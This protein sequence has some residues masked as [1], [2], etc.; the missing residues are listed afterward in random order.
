MK[1]ITI[2]GARA[3]NLKNI[4]I[5]IPKNKLVVATGVSGSG[6]S[7]LMF[8][9]IFEEGRK[10]YLQSLGILAGI[11]DDDKFDSIQ[12][13]SPAIAVQ[14]NIIRQSNVRSTVGSRTNIINLLALLY[15][16]EGTIAC[17]NCGIPVSDN[18][19]CLQCD[20]IEE[21]LPP[22]YFS[23][24][25]PNGMCIKCS[26]RGTYFEVHMEKL[27]TDYN[28]TLEQVLDGVRLTPGYLRL[29]HR[30]FTDYL[31][32]A[33]SELPEEVQ[34]EIIYGQYANGNSNKRSAC[35]INIFN[36]RIGRGEDI[37]GVYSKVHCTDCHGFRIGEEARRV[38]LNGKHIGELGQMTISEVN[39]HLKEV[40]QQKMLSQFGE[41]LLHDILRKVNNLIKARLGHLSLYREMPS[42]SGGEVQRLFLHAHLDLKMDSLIYVLDEPTAG[43]HVCEKI[44]LLESIY[45]LRDLGNTV[46]VVEHDKHAIKMADHIIDMGPKAGIEGGRVIYEGDLEGLLVCKESITGQYLLGLN[47]L[48][49]KSNRLNIESTH[50]LTIKHAKTNNLKD[51]T[52]TIPLGVM[53]GVA[54]MSGS[55]KSS[56]ISNTLLPLLKSYFRDQSSDDTEED[57]M[58]SPEDGVTKF[59]QVVADRLE[60]AEHICGYAEISQAPIGRSAISNPATYIGIWDKIRKLFAE[61]PESKRRH[62]SA[63]HFSFHTKG[64]CSLCSGSGHETIWLGGNLKINKTCAECHGKR[65]NEE[66]LSVTYKNKTIYDVLEMSVSEAVLF[67]E[68]S[69]N[70]I[71][72]LKVMERIGMGYIKLGQPTPTLSGGEAQRI[73]LAK[74][75]G[76]RR[77]G[78]ILYVLDEP[79]TGLSL[80]DTSKLIE[81][82]NELVDK[83]NSVLVIEHNSD[84]LSRCD[85]LI[86]LGPG[87]GADGGYIIGEG[88]PG[89]LKSNPTSL[90]GRYL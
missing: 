7:S 36:T 13:I 44:E 38:H 34:E 57:E 12:G 61:S 53:V 28:I 4:D 30:K 31:S 89:L 39:N 52:V 79:T 27:V 3:H 84:V 72:V 67:F 21:R 82:L 29:F 8:D 1:F 15:A 18:L 47:T 77:R 32:V 2:K 71:G 50:G 60:G 6:K 24:N 42:L 58:D 23:F 55:G 63:G 17:S 66:A 43:L 10:Q 59:T 25:S 19:S 69:S 73:K 26:G 14:Q 40:Q 48:P 41:N 80:Y 46:I 62:L 81:M 87:G 78:N 56:L 86:E 5:S 16:G 9:I 45:E 33:F 11:D 90:I 70:I 20:S 83:G 35:L 22:T 64:A 85:W 65:F 74:E 88:S 54:G 51:V 75:I 68:D 37:S 76:R 49:A